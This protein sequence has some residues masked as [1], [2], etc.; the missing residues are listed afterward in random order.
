MESLR[1]ERGSGWSEQRTYIKSREL[2]KYCSSVALGGVMGKGSDG[3]C[4]PSPKVTHRKSFTKQGTAPTS[5]TSTKKWIPLPEGSYFEN[6]ASCKS[7]SWPC[8]SKNF[9]LTMKCSPCRRSSGGC[10]TI[11]KSCGFCRF[12]ETNE[13]RLRESL[14]PPDTLPELTLWLSSDEM[15]SVVS[16]ASQGCLHVQLEH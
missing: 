11:S 1:E 14:L 16:I 6:L 8:S 9:S 15:S 10:V 7:Y 4:D 3:G 12:N 13:S 5:S 2:H